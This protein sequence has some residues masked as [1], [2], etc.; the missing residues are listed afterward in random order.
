MIVN[1]IIIVLHEEL[2]KATKNSNNMEGNLNL[3]QRNRDLVFQIFMNNFTENNRSI[4]SDLFYGVN[5]CIIQCQNPNCLS[6]VFN[7]Q[8]YYFIVFPLE[9]VR[10]LKLQCNP[11]SN[12]LGNIYDYF[13]YNQKSDLMM[14]DNTMHFNY[15][16]Y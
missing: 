6:R 8:I 13:Q 12:E 1:F 16:N 4:I 3:A 7:Y 14:G 10:K 2:N 11:N 5:C 9:E 15:L